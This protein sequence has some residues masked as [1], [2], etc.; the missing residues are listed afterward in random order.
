MET[1]N[2]TIPAPEMDF[3]QAE[4]ELRALTKEQLEGKWDYKG[5][6][7][8]AQARRTFD[9]GILPKIK[10]C[11][12]LTAILRRTNTGP[13]KSTGARGKRKAKAAPDLERIKASLVD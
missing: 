4:I 12:E 13:A 7:E 10:R 2:A 8:D 5:P 1:S 11:I 9:E 6:P 3:V